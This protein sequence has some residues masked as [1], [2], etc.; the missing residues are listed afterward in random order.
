MNI[1]RDATCVLS[2][3]ELQFVSMKDTNTNVQTVADQI[4]ANHLETHIRQDVEQEVIQDWAGFVRIA[5]SIYLL[6]IQTL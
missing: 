2:V 3:M 4:F 6:M 5:L 1:T